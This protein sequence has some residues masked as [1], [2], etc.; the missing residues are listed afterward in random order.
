MP[1]KSI[2]GFPT[3][4]L[5]INDKITAGRNGNLSRIKERSAIGRE[6]GKGRKKRYKINTEKGSKIETYIINQIFKLFFSS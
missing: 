1:L 4:L 5:T 2:K 3:D 6:A